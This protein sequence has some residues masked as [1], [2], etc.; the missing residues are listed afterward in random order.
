MQYPIID[1]RESARSI[2]KGSRS[3]LKLVAIVWGGLSSRSTAMSSLLDPT[4]AHL[5]DHEPT[6]SK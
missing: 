3:S 5:G 1:V 6:S 4:N 2:V